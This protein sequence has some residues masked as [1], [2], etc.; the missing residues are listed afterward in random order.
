VAELRDANGVRGD[1]IHVGQELTLARPFGHAGRTSVRWRRPLTAPAPVLR[2]FGV[3][4]KDA[5]RMTRSGV[6][7]A[8]PVGG[9]VRC[10]APGVL[11]F[12]G[13]MEPFG[14]LAILEHGGG[15][16]TVFAPLD[17]DTVPWRIG[18]ALLAG[19]EVGRTAAPRPDQGPPY[20]H[21]ELRH[22]EKAVAPDRL[23]EA[24]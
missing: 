11:R 19:D 8:Y 20:L 24:P 12:L 18:Q 15:Y 2:P 10:P 23:L 4:E 5:V 9:R 7:V 14:T 1:L 6:E 16:H 3:Y 13:E 22:H 21:I 17:P